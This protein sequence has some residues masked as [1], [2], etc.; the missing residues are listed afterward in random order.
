MFFGIALMVASIQT[1]P[2]HWILI[3][4]FIFG[5]V[6]FLDVFSRFL[7]RFAL[8]YEEYKKIRERDKKNGGP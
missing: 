4:A 2:F 7:L 1:R 3:F 6:L 8:F 5:L